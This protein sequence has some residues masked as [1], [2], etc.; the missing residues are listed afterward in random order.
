MY[1]MLTSIAS[2]AMRES[3]LSDFSQSLQEL[4]TTCR[5]SLPL[6]GPSASQWEPLFMPL[7]N[8]G[9]VVAFASEKGLD[10]IHNG[11]HAR[12]APQVSMDDEP[13]FAGGFGYRRGD[14]F[15]QRVF[16]RDK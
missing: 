6:S 14:T 4:C 7:T 2:D 1:I 8:T 15:E 3:N 16:V 13:I 5:R 12:G 9:E 10:P 11:S